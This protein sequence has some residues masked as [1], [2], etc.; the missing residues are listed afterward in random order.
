LKRKFNV[1]VK[2]CIACYLK[3]AHCV[4]DVIIA[5]NSR[6][7]FPAFPAIIYLLDLAVQCTAV[8]NTFI[9]HSCRIWRFV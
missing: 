4:C 7:T 5:C 1:V 6:G 3:H 9:S 2:P 8:G